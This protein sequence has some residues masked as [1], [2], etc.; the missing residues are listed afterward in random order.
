MRIALVDDEVSQLHLL[1]DLLAYELNS[2]TCQTSN[3]IDTYPNGQ[4]FLENWK[5]G[6]YDVIVLVIFMGGITGVDVAKQIRLTDPDVKLVFCSRSNEFAAESY[7]VNAQYYL[8]KPATQ[9]SVANMLKRLNLEMIQQ[10]QPVTLPN[11]HTLIQR[12][13]LYTEYFNHVI[14]IHLK[15]G[16]V[17]RLRGNHSTLEELL[18]PCGYICSPSKG[19]LINFY[20]ITELQDNH[21]LMSDGKVLPVSRRKSKYIQAEYTKFRFQKMRAEVDIS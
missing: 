14:Y 5:A 15:D 21:V 11:G 7:Q 13:I 4:A 10:M 8:L 1:N 16:T 18:I 3:I 19:I 12:Q 20:E 6:A 9:S 17:Y 2:L